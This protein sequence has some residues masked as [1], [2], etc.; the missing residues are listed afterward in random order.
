MGKPSAPPAP[1]YVGAAQ[2]QGAAN[3]EAAI[4]TAKLSNPWFSNAL[5]SRQVLYGDAAGTGDPL[6]PRVVDQLT[7][8]GEAR[9][10]QEN[11][12]I[13]ELGNVA[14][15]GLYRVGDAFRAPMEFND[16]NRLQDA[17]FNAQMARLNPV[18]NE[19]QAQLEAQLSNQGIKDRS[20]EA[21][22]NALRNFQMGRNDAE[23]QAILNA[24]NLQP[25]LM[26]QSLA[27]RN[28]PLNE[29]NALRSGSQV[30][31]PQFQA[32][33]GA[34]VQAAPLFAANQAAGQWQGDLFNQ[35]MGQYN[36]MMSGL[37]GIGS[38][39]AMGYA[40]RIK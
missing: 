22:V 1:D 25:Q 13:G 34:P 14:E 30:T 4:A 8:L 16:I 26:Q 9:Q 19:R 17:A 36:N 5:G 6:V 20:S 39:G 24:I 7:P 2:A 32:F 15:A 27:I 18:W 35:R 10:A 40:M 37:F 3:K 33:Q 28:Q 12:I 29:L 21:Y 31:L 38:A 23:S 11:R